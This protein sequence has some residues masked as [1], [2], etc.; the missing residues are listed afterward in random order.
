LCEAAGERPG[1]SSW[2]AGAFFT[3]KERYI[4]RS[5]LALNDG[6][7]NEDEFMWWF[8]KY[9]EEKM[10]ILHFTEFRY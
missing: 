7:N 3:E 4:P 5:E 8:V 1:G 2:R 6:F 10:A 9:P